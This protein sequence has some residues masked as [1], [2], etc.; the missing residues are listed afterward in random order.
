MVAVMIG[1]AG[2]GDDE[3]NAATSTPSSGGAYTDPAQPI[4]VTVGSQFRIVLESNPTTGYAWEITVPKEAPLRLVDQRFDGPDTTL[5]GAGGRQV[6]EFAATSAGTTTLAVF[7]YR[8]SIRTRGCSHR[9]QDLHRQRQWLRSPATKVPSD[10]SRWS[11]SE[12]H[13]PHDPWQ[14][15]ENSPAASE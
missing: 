8:R 10:L 4:Q 5:V 13:S 11:P 6:F 12:H 9:H 7:A 2:C 1:T 3:P 15:S 14:R